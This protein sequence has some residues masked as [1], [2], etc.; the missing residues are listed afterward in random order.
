MLQHFFVLKMSLN[1]ALFRHRNFLFFAPI[2][3]QSVIFRICELQ[4]HRLFIEIIA[5]VRIEWSFIVKKYRKV[6]ELFSTLM[7]YNG[8]VYLPNGFISVP[9]KFPR[10]FMSQSL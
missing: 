4:H 9:D 7:V 1:L 6:Q 10:F 3:S 5:A 8:W 2:L